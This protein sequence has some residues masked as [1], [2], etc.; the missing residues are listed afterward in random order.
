[1]YFNNYCPRYHCILH[2][3]SA[4]MDFVKPAALPYITCELN[5]Y[6]QLFS[7]LMMLCGPIGKFRRMF[8][9]M[10]S[11]VSRLQH[12]FIVTV[13]SLRLSSTETELLTLSYLYSLQGLSAE[14]CLVVYSFKARISKD[15]VSHTRTLLRPFF[16]VLPHP[17]TPLNRL[18]F[19]RCWILYSTR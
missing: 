19:C 3:C 16:P 11:E 1:M 9:F 18:W 6:L 17:P 7:L 5:H 12:G 13:V 2:V 14:R 4:W 15:K 8:W 10:F